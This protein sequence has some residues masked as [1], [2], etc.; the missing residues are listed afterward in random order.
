MSRRL[1]D[2]RFAGDASFAA[3]CL[4]DARRDGFSCEPHGSGLGFGFAPPAFGDCCWRL[5]DFY[6]P[7]PLGLSTHSSSLPAR[8]R[9]GV[10]T[11]VP[12]SRMVGGRGDPDLSSEDEPSV[13][14][15]RLAA[16]LAAARLAACWPVGDMGSDLTTFCSLRSSASS[17]A[18]S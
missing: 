12:L 10:V 4:G 5:G 16:F 3:A 7:L 15:P 1:G 2:A 13:D 18:S 17:R 9:L 11:F 6:Q 14:S 8:R